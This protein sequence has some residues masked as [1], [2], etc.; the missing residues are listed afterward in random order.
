MTITEA[1]PTPISE[2]DDEEERPT[3]FSKRVSDI[4]SDTLETRNTGAEC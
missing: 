2:D 4:V 3:P 1:S